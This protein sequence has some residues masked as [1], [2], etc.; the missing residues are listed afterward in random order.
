MESKILLI[1]RVDSFGIRVRYKRFY[2]DVL[3][4]DY[5]CCRFDFGQKDS[6]DLQ[7]VS[8]VCSWSILGEKWTKLQEKRKAE[9][10]FLGWKQNHKWPR[11]NRDVITKDLYITRQVSIY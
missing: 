1:Q 9:S 10:I 3:K 11:Q 5:K 8:C 4:G 2:H 7:T 6:R